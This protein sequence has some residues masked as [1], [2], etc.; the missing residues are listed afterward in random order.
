MKT[1][2]TKINEDRVM[3]ESPLLWPLLRRT[4]ILFESDPKRPRLDG[5]QVNDL[6]FTNVS[7]VRRFIRLKRRDG[8]GS[9]AWKIWVGSEANLV[10][11]VQ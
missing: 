2:G 6:W 4:D 5:A 8:K 11:P 3:I 9:Y 10:N 1:Q 7:F